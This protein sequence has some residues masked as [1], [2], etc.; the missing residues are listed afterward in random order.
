M[1]YTYDPYDPPTITQ[2]AAEWR[3]LDKRIKDFYISFWQR[4]LQPLGK[5]VWDDVAKRWIPFTWYGYEL[6]PKTPMAIA[7]ANWGW[8][9]DNWGF[10]DTD[11]VAYVVTDPFWH[12]PTLQP[13]SH[14][15]GSQSPDPYIDVA[16]MAEPYPR[17]FY[18][19]PKSYN[20]GSGQRRRNL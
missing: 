16:A 7:I 9:C 6:P 20:P 2:Y 18:R 12:G 4:Y 14:R 11:I 13:P 17:P 10:W 3:A 1:R 8:Q 5:A 19:I 15:F